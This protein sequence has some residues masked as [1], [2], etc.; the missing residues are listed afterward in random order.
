MPSRDGD[1]R[2]GLGVVSNFLDEVGCLLDDFLVPGF[3]PFGSIHLVDSN[4][5]LLDTEGVGQKGVFT[6]L[7]IL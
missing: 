4:D 7:T 2:N 6:S 3:G 1:E 5:E